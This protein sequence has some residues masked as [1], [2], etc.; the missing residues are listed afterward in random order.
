MTKENVHLRL[1]NDLLQ[2]QQ[3]QQ[4]VGGAGTGGGGVIKGTWKKLKEKRLK[5]RNS[6]YTESPTTPG[7][8][9]ESG[10]KAGKLII[11]H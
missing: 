9:A 10:K 5:K 3:Q 11:I 6:A 7:D 2:Q 8:M 4:G 1:G